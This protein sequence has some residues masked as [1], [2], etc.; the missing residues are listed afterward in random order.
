VDS[1]G[2][3]A[4]LFMILTFGYNIIE[5]K[6]LDLQPAANPSR[7]DRCNQEQKNAAAKDHGDEQECQEEMNNLL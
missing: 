6:T 3:D 1:A 4:E 7:H 5:T 2:L